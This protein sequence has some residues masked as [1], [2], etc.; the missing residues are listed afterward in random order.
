MRYIN[1]ID[2]Y[3]KDANIKMASEDA[4][5]NLEERQPEIIGYSWTLV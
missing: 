2:V 5:I 4:E 3:L 1:L